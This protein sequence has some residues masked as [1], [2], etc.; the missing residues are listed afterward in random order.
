MQAEHDAKHAINLPNNEELLQ[1]SWRDE[2]WEAVA[3]YN[4]RIE[5]HGCFSDGLRQF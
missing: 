2:N 4:R 1:Q 5:A 3:K